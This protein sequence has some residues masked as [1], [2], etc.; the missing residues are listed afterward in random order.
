[1]ENIDKMIK[2]L[3]CLRQDNTPD[4]KEQVELHKK[5]YMLSSKIDINLQRSP[6]IFPDIPS[7]RLT[8]GRWSIFKDQL[9][10]VLKCPRYLDK[11]SDSFFC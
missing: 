5:K 8:M 4:E 1:M 3:N 2:W 7:R 9:K 10:K 11:C 6:V